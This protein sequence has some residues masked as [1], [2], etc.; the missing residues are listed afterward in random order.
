VTPRDAFLRACALDVAVRK[1]GNV[2]RDAPGHG[3]QATQF[4]DSA[5]VAADVLCRAGATVGERIEGAV[6]ATRAAVGC[7]T[8]LGIVLLCAPI[9]RAAEQTHEALRDSI[10]STLAA[11]TVED[12]AAAFR[13]IALAQPGGLGQAQDQDVHAVPTVDLRAAMA[14]AAERDRIARQYRDGF[15]ELFELAAPGL[16]SGFSLPDLAPDGLPDA[17]TVAAVQGLYLLL[18]STRHDSHIVRKQGETVAQN[19][20]AVAQDWC[21]R[22]PGTSGYDAD[23]AFIAWDLDLKHH[24]INPGTTADLTVATLMI[25]ALAALRRA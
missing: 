24:G 18:L 1:P 19:V 6:V 14:L 5:R 10:V 20:M 25:A 12:A 7:N 22:G 9:A 21:R 8:N 16:P 15:D 13:A 2:C 3:M 4:L 23:P 17:A 11:L